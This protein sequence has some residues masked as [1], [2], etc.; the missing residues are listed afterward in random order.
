VRRR[1]SASATI[2]PPMPRPQ[3]SSRRTS[4]ETASPTR[5][6]AGDQIDLKLGLV[7]LG[8]TSRA[9]HLPA[10]K[11][12]PPPEAAR[13]DRRSP[14]ERVSRLIDVVG[15]PDASIDTAQPF[16]FRGLICQ[17]ESECKKQ[18]RENNSDHMN[19]LPLIIQCRAI[20]LTR[21]QA[22]VHPAKYCAE[23]MQNRAKRG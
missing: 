10:A 19:P 1:S 23:L 22:Q 12:A 21:T 17:D 5:G 11:H 4:S 7:P 15:H 2:S 18:T 6:R 8:S 13:I 14:G 16:G 9:D 3:K 20:A